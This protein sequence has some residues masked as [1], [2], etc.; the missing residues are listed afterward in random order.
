MLLDTGSSD[1]VSGP[2]HFQILRDYEFSDEKYQWVVSSNCTDEDCQAI[3]KYTQSSSAS[4]SNL[5]F[6]LQYLIGS[7]NGSIGS[8]TV[9]FGPFS[10][11][12]QVLGMS[13]SLYSSISAE[14]GRYTAR[15]NQRD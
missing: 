8:D 5:P 12:S 15:F 3:P 1:L 6:H 10:V 9:T 11:T 4:M 14:L 2:I 13:N 7:V